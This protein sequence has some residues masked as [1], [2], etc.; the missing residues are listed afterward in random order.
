MIS[1]EM[2][3]NEV[4]RQTAEK[5]TETALLIAHKHTSSEKSY[6]FVLKLLLVQ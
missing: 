1:E 6:D 5:C 3:S 2:L 4:L